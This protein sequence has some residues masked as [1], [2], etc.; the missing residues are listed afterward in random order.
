LPEVTI[1]LTILGEPPLP[2]ETDKPVSLKR[3]RM[4]EI[5]QISVTIA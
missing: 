2:V 1:A 3:R 4:L 5:W